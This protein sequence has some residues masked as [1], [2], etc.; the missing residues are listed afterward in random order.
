[1]AQSKLYLLFEK[2]HY[3]DTFFLLFFIYAIKDIAGHFAVLLAKT[4][5]VLYRTL[6]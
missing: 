6:S 3:F 1:M 4:K 2:V 5:I